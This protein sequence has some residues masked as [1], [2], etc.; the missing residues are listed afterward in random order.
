MGQVSKHR[1]GESG[2]DHGE[3]NIDISNEALSDQSPVLLA[4]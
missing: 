4:D 1:L 3:A 2:V